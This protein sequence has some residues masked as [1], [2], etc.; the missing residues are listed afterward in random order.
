MEDTVIGLNSD[1]C[2][3]YYGDDWDEENFDESKFAFGTESMHR[4]FMNILYEWII[5][6]M[7]KKEIR[8]SKLSTN[9]SYSLEDVVYFIDIPIITKI[10]KEVS[11]SSFYQLMVEE[12]LSLKYSCQILDWMIRNSDKGVKNQR[13]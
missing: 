12:G 1:D 7:K 13:W 3:D 11:C 10:F 2:I 9:Q 8:K 6:D 4:K 5:E